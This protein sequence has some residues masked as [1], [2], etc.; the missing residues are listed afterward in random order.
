MLTGWVEGFSKFFPSMAEAASMQFLL[1][2]HT[3]VG[4]QGCR[5]K[6]W[7]GEGREGEAEQL[8]K[9]RAGPFLKHCL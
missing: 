6:C 7:L 5:C 4:Q 8:G 1:R 2:I 9:Y 3:M